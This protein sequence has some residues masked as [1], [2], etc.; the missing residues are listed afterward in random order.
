MQQGPD[1]YRRFLHPVGPVA[2][3]EPV[4]AAQSPPDGPTAPDHRSRG[5]PPASAPLTPDL[6]V[7]RCARD[8]DHSSSSGGSTA[9]LRAH[10]MRNTGKAIPR[11]KVTPQTRAINVGSQ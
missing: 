3:C 10:G 4:A 2:P 7:L 1:I 6:S 5:K 8:P 11:I 9:A